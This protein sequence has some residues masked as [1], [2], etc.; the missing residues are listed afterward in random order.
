VPH[1]STTLGLGVLVLA[2]ALARSARADETVPVEI[3]VPEPFSLRGVG[4]L[5]GT[6]AT[7]S[8]PCT[9][10]L[11]PGTYTYASSRRTGDEVA[12]TGPSRL[13]LHGPA[14]PL[15]T[16]GLVMAGVGL[17][18]VTLPI[19][20]I[21]STCTDST[22]DAFGRV[23]PRSCVRFGESTDKTLAIV[24]GS[25]FFLGVVGAIVFF[26]TSG[27]LTVTDVRPVAQRGLRA[28]LL[29]GGTFVF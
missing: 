25:G 26:A 14:E 27:G 5:T 1:R 9:L 16:A 4:G 17:L 15:H 10:H 29:R 2:T 3:R 12:F 23:T 20:A 8:P 19:I 18:G 7:C 21:F 11:V 28:G 6:R 24:A 13:D 22:V